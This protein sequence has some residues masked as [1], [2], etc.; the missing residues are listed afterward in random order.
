[1]I[2]TSKSDFVIPARP[3]IIVELNKLQEAGNPR[4][5]SV[6]EIVKSDA[7]LY[8]N[9]LALINSAYFGIRRRISSIH[10]A[11][12]IL[13]VERAMSIVRMAAL[14]SEL[15]H[16]GRMDQFWDDASLT[17][18]MCSQLSRH[19]QH[20]ER[21]DAYT[22]GMMNNC[23]VP[24]LYRECPGYK[25][26]YEDHSLF[27]LSELHEHELQEFD[28]DRFSVSAQIAEAWKIPTMICQ[29]I[30]LQPLY[31]STLNSDE[32]SED[33]RNV[34]AMLLIAKEFSLKFSAIWG[35]E[36]EYQPVIDMEPV[37]E[38]LCLTFSDIADIQRAVFANIKVN[39]T[40]VVPT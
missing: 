8:S 25:T 5:D 29:A 26:F 34:L 27:D 20:L 7:S 6:A 14:R 17:A 40:G 33:V 13:G 28:V 31:Y 3:E 1:M 38:Q 2:K 15:T 37:L 36:E 22:M 35:F 10:D 18:S 39:D 19:V 11:V 9:T 4:V 16:T 12:R 21:D 32:Y 30:E 23:G 24:L